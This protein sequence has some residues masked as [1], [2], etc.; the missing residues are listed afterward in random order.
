MHKVKLSLKAIHKACFKNFTKHEP[1]NIQL[2][3]EKKKM[4]FIAQEKQNKIR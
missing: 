3:N 1:N 4:L 2:I